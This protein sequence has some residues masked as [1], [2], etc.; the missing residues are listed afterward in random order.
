M[1]SPR[2]FMCWN[3]VPNICEIGTLWADGSPELS[4]APMSKEGE[5]LN[6]VTDISVVGCWPLCMVTTQYT[7]MAAIVVEIYSAEI[8]TSEPRTFP[9]GHKNWRVHR[10]PSV[11]SCLCRGLQNCT[12][13]GVPRG[14]CPWEP[15]W[16]HLSKPSKEVIAYKLSVF[17]TAFLWLFAPQSLCNYAHT[18]A[19]IDTNPCKTPMLPILN[20]P[21]VPSRSV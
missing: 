1:I 14:S 13:V 10:S 21:Q 15:R 16:Y 20:H 17:R 12:F 7:G 19:N 5:R 3:R 18:L 9:P 4:T 8:E 11:L 2:L 6:D